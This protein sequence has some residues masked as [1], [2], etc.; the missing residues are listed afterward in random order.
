MVGGD[1]AVGAVHVPQ[2][3]APL[4]LIERQ[5]RLHETIAE[6]VVEA[7]ARDDRVG[8]DLLGLGDPG[9]LLELP[10]RE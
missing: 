5:H 4:G 6:C 3:V 10:R 8:R 2:K 7:G 9:H 1:V